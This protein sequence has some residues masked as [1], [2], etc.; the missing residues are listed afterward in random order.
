MYAFTIVSFPIFMVSSDGCTLTLSCGQ[1][2]TS[3]IKRQASCL[4]STSNYLLTIMEKF[5][6]GDK[7]LHSS[8]RCGNIELTLNHSALLNEAVTDFLCLDEN[9]VLITESD[10]LS[11]K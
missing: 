8:G 3:L 9:A 6:G 11:S 7:K 5:W 1:S 2:Y 4:P 10:D